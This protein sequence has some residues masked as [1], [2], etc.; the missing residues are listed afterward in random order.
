M[1]VPLPDLRHL[2]IEAAHVFV[3]QVVAV[4]AAIFIEGLRDFALG[5][6][7]DIAPDAAVFNSQLRGHRAVGVDGVAAVN[8]EVRQTQAHGF[9]DAHAADVRVDAEALA[10]GIA[11]PHKTN[12]AALLRHAAQVA[13]PRLAGDAGLGVFKVHAIENRLIDRQPGEFD[14]GGEVGAAVGQRRDE[15]TRVA[16]HTAGVPLHHH[17]RGAVAAAPD[18]RAV[19]QQV[20]GLHTIGELRPVFHRGDH[21]RG[22]AR[23]Q[24]TGAD[25]L[26]H[27]A[28]A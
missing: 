4:V 28:T 1:I 5:F 23:Q 22:Q 8:K 18:H 19:A 6:G 11:A 12:V 27:A 15:F 17:L 7:G 16:E 10:D 2:G 24:Q 26:H 9:V 3:E 21:R 25:G 14:A 20:A 13:E